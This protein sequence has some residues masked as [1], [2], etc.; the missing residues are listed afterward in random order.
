MV[1]GDQVERLAGDREVDVV[2]LIIGQRVV[3]RE[4][5]GELGL[6]ALGLVRQHLDAVREPPVRHEVIIPPPKT[7]SNAE[8][9]K[10]NHNFNLYVADINA[11]GS[12]G[13]AHQAQYYTT[14]SALSPEPLRNGFTFSYQ[15]ST[16]NFRRWDLQTVTSSGQWGPLLGY[17]Q[18]SELY[19]FGTLLTRAQPNGELH[20]W[21]LGVKYYNLNN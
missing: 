16:E 13:Q 9:D 8:V 17:A 20:D 5:V 10:A 12:L 4:H 1:N 18:S 7:N 11:D 2:A 3:G 15:S 6:A 19:H 21:F 14:T